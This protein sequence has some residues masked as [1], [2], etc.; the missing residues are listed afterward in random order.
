MISI[1]LAATSSSPRRSLVVDGQQT[2]GCRHE[3]CYVCFESGIQHLKV[4]LIASGMQESNLLEGIVGQLLQAPIVKQ[5]QE[6][7][8]GA[9]R[10][11]TKPI[12]LGLCCVVIGHRAILARGRPLLPAPAKP[13]CQLAA[14]EVCD[15][16]GELTTRYKPIFPQPLSPSGHFSSL[17]YLLLKP[18]SAE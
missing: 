1:D 9:K 13:D 12:C 5:E 17:R 14:P 2:R 16:S 7:E 4:S 6:T 8:L 18:I 3:S 11:G 10:H 15:S